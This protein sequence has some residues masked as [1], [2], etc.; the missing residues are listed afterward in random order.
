MALGDGLATLRM[1][2]TA[3]R[4]CDELRRLII[5]GALEPGQALNEKHV[6]EQ[7]GVSRSPVRE[8]L[9]RLVAERLLV[10]ER[11]KTVTVKEFTDDDINQIYDARVAIESHAA[12]TVISA[13]PQRVRQ[14]CERL[15]GAVGD[16][17]RAVEASD[18]LQIAEADLAFHQQLVRCGGN[19]RLLDAYL[20]LSAETLACMSWLEAAHPSGDELIQ[21]HRDLIHAL[22]GQ[23][24]E[25]TRRVITQHL[26]RASS[27]LSASR[28]ADRSDPNRAQRLYF[29]KEPAS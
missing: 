12:V 7:L 11:N 13:G 1:R 17:P 8:A 5:S 4:V 24:P 29:D 26:D 18:R 28:P 2:S 25:H 6:A 27:K 20:V 9:Q 21:D 10:G 16:F 15:E 19:A 3:D 22:N 23:D 14:A